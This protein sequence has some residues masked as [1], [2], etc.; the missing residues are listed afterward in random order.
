[1]KRYLRSVAIILG[2]VAAFGCSG[3]SPKPRAVPTPP[4]DTWTVV[5]SAS[6]SQALV[7][8][9]VV[10]TAT[11]QRNG[12]DAPDGTTVEF[13]SST[14]AVFANGSTQAQVAT[15]GG[16]AQ[17]LH[18]SADAGTYIV[19]AQIAA[20]VSQTQVTYREPDTPDV[21]QLLSVVPGAGS[22]DGGEQVTITATG[23][24]TP[25]E[26]YFEVTQ[27]GGDVGTFQAE[28]ISVDTGLSATSTAAEASLAT[29][30]IT[31]M[32]PA[33]TGADPAKEGLA[34]VRVESGVGTAN[35]E[36]ATL[37]DIFRFLATTSDPEIYVLVPSSGSA[38]GGE[39][40]SVIGRNFI[41]PV[42]VTF[43]GLPADE[44]VL[45]G[46]GTQISVTTPQY[47]ASPLNE[48]TAVD[49]VVRSEAG[50]SREKTAT[51][52]N[53]FVFLAD[54]PT[55]AISAISPTGGP[56]DGGTRVSIFG[57]GFDFP[58]Q[59]FFGELEA[60]VV[61]V[62]RNQIVCVA[63]D[64]SA[65]PN[66]NPPEIV[67]VQVVNVGSGLTSTLQGAYTYGENL[68]ISGNT[69]TEGELGTL[70][71]IY[72]SGFVD[73][74]IVD[75]GD[76]RLDVIAVSGNELVV[77]IPTTIQPDCEEITNSFTVTL[78]DSALSVDGGTFTI[79][80]NQPTV[81]SVDP[82][83][84]SSLSDG[85]NVTPTEAT[86]SGLR[87]L[88]GAT[89]EFSGPLA[90]AYVLPSGDVTY[91]DEN[92]IDV[93][94]PAPNDFGLIW[95]TAQCVTGTGLT[96]VRDIATPVNVGVTNYPGAC[97]DTLTAAVVFEPET[98]DC[99]V[100]P[101][102]SVAPMLFPDTDAAGVIT[103]NPVSPVT[104]SITN[105]GAGTLDIT[106]M[107]TV[108]RFFFDAGCSN[109]ALGALSIAP[110][111]FDSSRT[112]YFCPD[113]DNAQTYGGI[114]SIVSNAPGSPT[115]INLSGIELSPQ[116][117]V[118]PLALNF[119]PGGSVLNITIS[120]AAGTSPLTW[121]AVSPLP[122]SFTLGAI[123]SPIAAGG[124][125]QLAVTYTGTPGGPVNLPITHD[126]TTQATPINVS[127]TGN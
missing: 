11:V 115:L 62:D 25:V 99:V 116:I 44:A 8:Q 26:V 21:L 110:F 18:S 84:F 14:G 125:T 93:N 22:L 79:L 102:I 76:I 60:Q 33:I 45:S 94:V 105:T 106:S 37:N 92:T 17:I 40:V 117:L 24:Q 30:S 113:V 1:M 5:V 88:P 57:T 48:D 119:P 85:D 70:I 127:L 123:N 58:A 66:V 13:L 89:V 54:Q 120:N 103:A 29:G 39:Q 109:Q 114:L 32:T 63:P 12:S 2:L 47:S 53:G 51:K 23:I 6:P 38:S 118:N 126:D 64:Y 41:A 90:P 9:V 3:D 121:N 56:L 68:F 96:G 36:S 15:S 10:A 28:V 98:S 112:V 74:L 100:A 42:Q 35:Q 34:D 77:R 27:D 31:V 67:D 71:T 73:P 7:N 50:T 82:L 20:V 107:S 104:I 83:T 91:V 55:P 65:V 43:G 46:D 122:G 86:I 124:S 101:G 69:P 19:Q 49:V 87:F 61:N 78:I 111:G 52:T 72:G 59:V 81:L 108:G 16:R 97:T 75:F 80:G 4:A 95:D